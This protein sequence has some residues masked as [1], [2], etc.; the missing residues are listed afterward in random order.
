MYFT[1]CKLRTKKRAI[2]SFII[3][4][5][6]EYNPEADAPEVFGLSDGKSRLNL[7][8][9]E[10]TWDEESQNYSKRLVVFAEKVE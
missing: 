7:I 6:R 5:S 2:T 8:T 9:C 10:G 4:E 3:F 1:K